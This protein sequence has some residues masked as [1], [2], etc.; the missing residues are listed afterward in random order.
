MDQIPGDLSDMI[1]SKWEHLA[2]HKT[3]GTM[4]KVEHLL[5]SRK[6]KSVRDEQREMGQWDRIRAEQEK[7]K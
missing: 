3:L 5:T 6:F 2:Q 4:K 1:G 7:Q